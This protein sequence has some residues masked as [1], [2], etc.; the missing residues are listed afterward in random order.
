PTETFYNPII[1]WVE[2]LILSRFG[3]I[4]IKNQVGKKKYRIDQINEL[5]KDY[6]QGR[7]HPLDLKEA[8]IFSLEKMLE[9][10]QIYFN[11]AAPKKILADFEQ[12]KTK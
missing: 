9:P 6:N 2:F 1:D 11:Q 8:V 7:I 4:E 10:I 3:S 12:F 5:K